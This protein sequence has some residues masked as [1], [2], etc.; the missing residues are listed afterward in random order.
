MAKIVVVESASLIR[1]GLVQLISQVAPGCTVHGLEPRQL[2]QEPACP[3][4]SDLILL[5]LNSW[6]ELPELLEQCGRVFADTPVVLLANP[7]TASM[8]DAPAFT[9]N[10]VGYLNTNS[11]EDIL[12]ASV[13]LVMAGGTCFPARAKAAP[14]HYS[15]ETGRESFKTSVAQ[16]GASPARTTAPDEQTPSAHNPFCL[17]PAV[18]SNTVPSQ[19][20]QPAFKVRAI[21]EGREMPASAPDRTANTETPPGLMNH[22]GHDSGLRPLVTSNPV[23]NHSSDQP[24]WEML[25]L[26]RRQY[27]VLVLLAR[28]YPMKTVGRYLNISVAT[29][30]AHTETLYQR[31]DVHNR[32]AA[33]Y[34]AVSRGATL[35]WPGIAHT[36][37]A[38]AG[39]S[40]HA[41]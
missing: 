19:T 20:S 10:V 29:A 14:L 37:Q 23:M 41:Q 2:A 3:A 9:H 30:K 11:P 15:A 22:D 12:M 32:N 34:V 5:G 24:E 1:L 6:T 26:T 18:S 31:L 33:V 35:G 17:A 7:D 36:Q 28:G 25:G 39:N 8:A 21:V 4:P 38:Y 27:E 16:T 13:R 40:G